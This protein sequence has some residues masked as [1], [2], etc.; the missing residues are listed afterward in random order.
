LNFV[1]RA[2]KAK[3]E[4]GLSRARHNES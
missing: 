1:R 2:K 4:I 3:K